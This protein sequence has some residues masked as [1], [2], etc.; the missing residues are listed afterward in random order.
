M[1][2]F[3]YG[4][5]TLRSRKKLAEIIKHYK[6]SNKKGLDLK[7][8]D[9]E[10]LG[11]E[12]LQKE[13]QQSSIFQE[14]KLL[15]LRNVF[16]QDDFRNKFSKNHKDFL[17]SQNIIVLFEEKNIPA[18]SKLLKVLAK[19]AKCQAFE[20]LGEAELEKWVRT[21][22]RGLDGQ[23]SEEAVGKLLE[24]VG[25]DLWRLDNE[26]KKLVSFKKKK[27]VES[28]DIELLVRPK[29]ETDI[30]KTIDAM[31]QKNKKKALFLIHKHLEKGDAPLYLL[32]MINFQFRNLL[33]V[34][35][36]MEKGKPYYAILKLVK[37]HPFV[38]KKSYQQAG[39][40]SYLELKKIYQKIFRVDLDIKTG[41]LRPE[42]A[43]DML[44]TGI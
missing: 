38:V 8:L 21:E 11:F 29:I 10:N 18:N 5:D 15:I 34:K 13:I 16:S 30:F 33:V 40:F 9:A 3:I 39:R 22:I 2:I 17:G 4:S 19:D 41:R 28:E 35:D 42:T 36:L 12:D 24:F 14:K 1:I 37:L 43:L 25:S 26:I 7:Y 6:E 20:P 31:A 32:S 44:I 23:I 27:K